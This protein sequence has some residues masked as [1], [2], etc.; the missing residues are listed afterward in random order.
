MANNRPRNPNIQLN[1]VEP[2]FVRKTVSELKEIYSLPPVETDED[3]EQR[4]LDFFQFCERTGQ[5]PGVELL[6]LFLGRTRQTI[7]NWEHGIGCSLERTEMINHCK[8]LITSFLEQA[9]LSGEVN[10]ISCLFLSKVWMGYRENDDI[11]VR[12]NPQTSQIPQQT[13]EQIARARHI[14]L[15]EVPVPEKPNLE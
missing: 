13:I 1:D 15:T 5:R 6:T 7:N 9:H 2:S 3:V 8:S 14:S 10:A 11:T 4:I 12:L